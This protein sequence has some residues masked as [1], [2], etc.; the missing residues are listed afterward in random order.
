VSF[1]R[2]HE[3][4]TAAVSRDLSQAER[5]EMSVDALFTLVAKP[6]HVFSLRDRDRFSGD[7]LIV[8]RVIKGV[9]LTESEKAKLNPQQLSQLMTL[10]RS[11]S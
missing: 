1:Q 4:L 11:G 8:V 5:D 9:E 6:G 7:Q 3:L 2:D 10:Q